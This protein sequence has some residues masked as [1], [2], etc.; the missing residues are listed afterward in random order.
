MSKEYRHIG[1][2]TPRMAAL[3]FVTGKAMYVRDMKRPHMLYGKVMRSPYS[4]ANIK[5][6]DTSKAEAYPGVRAIL[7]YRNAPDWYLGVPVPHLRI[8]DNKVRF[9]GD[10]VALVAA[11][12]EEIAE[13]AV[14]LIEVEYEPLPAVYDMEDAMKPDAPQLYEVFPGNLIPNRLITERLHHILDVDIGDPEQGFREAD[15]IVEGTAKL[16]NAQ[17][18]LPMETPGVIAEWEGDRL[19]EWGSFSSPGL[20]MFRAQAEMRLPPGNLRLIAAYVGGSFGSKHITGNDH[21]ILYAAALA[22]AAHRPVGIFYTREEHFTS[23]HVRMGCRAS[24]RVGMKKDG[25]VTAI[26]G[27]WLCNCGAFSASQGLMVA[28]GL[29]ALAV[30][31]RC[32]NVNVKTK[33]VLTNTIPSGPY[34]GFGYLENTAVLSSVLSMAMEKA[35]LNP[36]DYYKKNCLKPGDRFYHPYFGTGF[37]VSAGPDI[38]RAI[39]KGAEL[40][41]WENKWKGWGKP[42][43]VHGTKRR[44]VGMGVAGETDTG[45]RP[46]NENVQLNALGSV[47]VYCC[48]TEFGTGTRDVVRK[49]VAEALDIPLERVGVTPPDTLINPY[50][51][52]S[53]GSRSTY[54]MGAAVLA[55]AEDAKRKLFQ[56][57]APMLRARPE[58]LETRDGFVYVRGGG[59]RK[60]PWVAVMGPMGSITGEGHFPGRSN[61]PAYQ[62]QFVEVEVDVETGEIELLNLV[63][64]TDCGQI[65]DPLALQNQ[66]QGFHPGVDLALREETVVD[67]ATGRMLNPNMIDY[68]VRTFPELPRHQ[69]VILET[70]PQADPPCPFGAFGVGEPSLAPALPAITMAVYNAIGKRFTDY[71]ITPDKVLK[72]LRETREGEA[73]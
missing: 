50:E 57:A 20:A 51:S 15:I 44:G 9:A 71:P 29:E 41:G 36:V 18:P 70:P 32:P 30:L 73:V 64:S 66:L 8:L 26:T 25:T 53:T 4:H 61:L 65:V 14:E 38:T 46:S 47:T 7:T 23:Y 35:N 55:A 59:E 69:F 27:E 6:I 13:E 37:E 48:A 12:T 40:F 31:A 39:E 21:L 52:G 19:T 62:V 45:E 72:A 11:D 54:A 17:N 56:R 63:S 67:K 22:K 2:A 42:T 34:R 49:I 5:D 16:E 58:D 43:V 3:E 10:A 68:K 24:Y 60:L 33:L 28:V 1:K